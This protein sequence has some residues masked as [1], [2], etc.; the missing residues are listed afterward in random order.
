MLDQLIANV[1]QKTGI[2]TDKAQQ[3]VGE[4]IAHLKAHLPGPVAS[5]IDQVLAGNYQSTITDVEQ[6][7]KGKLGSMLGH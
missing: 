3:A 6:A 5:H 2:S 4:V 7:V 1:S